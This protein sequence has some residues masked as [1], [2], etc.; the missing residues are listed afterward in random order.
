[1]KKNLLISCLIVV[2]CVFEACDKNEVKTNEF[3]VFFDSNSGSEVIPQMVKEGEKAT[4]PVDPTRYGYVFKAW[5]K[6]LFF[7][8]EWIFDQDVVAS[9]TTLYALWEQNLLFVTFYCYDGY[10][11]PTQAMNKGEKATEPSPAPTREGYRFEGWYTYN[12]TKWDFSTDIVSYNITLFAR[13]IS[14]EEIT[15]IEDMSFENYPQVDGSTSARA[16]NV[17]IACKL[18]GVQYTWEMLT[19][20]PAIAPGYYEWVVA[21]DM[22]A[23]PS[24]YREELF[25]KRI[26]T[27]QT[28]GAFMNLIDGTADIILTHRTLSDD[29]KNDADAASVTLIETPIALDVFVF[30]VRPGNAVKSLTVEQIQKIYTGEITRW[31]E[32]GGNNAQINVFTRPRN[33]GSE[34]VFRT[35]VMNGIAPADF[36]AVSEIGGMSLVFGEVRNSNGICYTFNNYKDMIVRVPDNEIPKIAI[37]GIFPDKNTVSNNTYPFISKVH[38]AIRSDLDRNSMA[39][40]LYEWLQSTDAIQTIVECGFI[41][42]K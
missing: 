22:Q 14:I 5:N 18:L 23:I 2:L 35:L 24:Q 40:K 29:E 21:P 9:D 13:W 33:S 26:V 27:S 31:S 10:E 11:V 7:F 4:K 32:V 34:E 17:M 8:D 38:V 39:Y 19:G 42:I 16:L 28:H 12:N 36:T 1:M 6:E 15:G 41:P 37:N 30:I 3:S 25:G 20:N